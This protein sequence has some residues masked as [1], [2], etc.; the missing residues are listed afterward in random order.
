MDIGMYIALAIVIVAGVIAI[1]LYYRA[2]SGENKR[3][4]GA[5]NAGPV[6]PRPCG[7][8]VPTPPLCASCAAPLPSAA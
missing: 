2:A 7:T 4:G 5:V 1:V 6:T 8:R 3:H